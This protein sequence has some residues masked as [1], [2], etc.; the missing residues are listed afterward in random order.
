MKR[1]SLPLSLL[2]ASVAFI[3]STPADQ[4]LPKTVDFSKHIRPIFA[5]KCFA[6]HGPDRGQRKAG[7]HFNT[8]EG[9]FKDLDGHFAI[10]PGKPE[11]SE[12]IKRIRAEDVDERMPPLETNKKITPREF[13]L[14]KKWI[15]QGAEWQE[16]WSFVKLTRPPVPSVAEKS[17]THPV[18]RFIR[19]KLKE[20]GLNASARAEKTT[21]VRRLYFDLLGL[22]P[23]PKEVDA[24]VNNTDEDAYE[25]LVDRLLGT[26][27]Y[28]ERM[29]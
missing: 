4:P 1:R 14:L 12:L 8:K 24:F 21:L 20:K 19:T 22:P 23:E 5:D 15:E 28:G 17:V 2:I 26:Q 7:L 3:A 29:A 13:Q 16:H 6:C 9:A 11:E 10:V 27:H 25:K 18:D